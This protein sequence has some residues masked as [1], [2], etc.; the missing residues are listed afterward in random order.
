MKKFFFIALA[1]MYV[2]THAQNLHLSIRAGMFN[3]NGELQSKAFTLNQ[4]KPGFGIGVRHDIT[5]H[6]SARAHIHFTGLQGNDKK[7]TSF[8]QQRNL[9]FK[10]KLTDAE[11]GVQYNISN[12]NDKWWTPYLFAGVG[13]MKYKPYTYS[14]TGQKTYLQPLSTEGQGVLPGTTYPLLW[15]A[16]MH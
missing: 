13:I 14:G 5:E 1:F 10:T 8:M 11:L 12:L 9:S 16:N 2:T 4:A 6:F 15:V 3:Y 7:G